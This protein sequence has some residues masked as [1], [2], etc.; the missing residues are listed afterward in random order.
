MVI[1]NVTCKVEWTIHAR[2]LVWVKN[3]HI[4]EMLATGIFYHAQ[5]VK[6]IDADETDGATYALQFYTHTL[7]GYRRFMTGSATGI[8]ASQY[9]LWQDSIVTFATVM[10]LV[11]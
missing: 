7:D 6:L 3:S 4:P 11:E 8:A 1:Y 10:E 5:L 2:W 9:S